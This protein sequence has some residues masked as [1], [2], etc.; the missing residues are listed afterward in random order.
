MDRGFAGRGW[1]KVGDVGE[2]LDEGPLLRNP[3]DG[4]AED[5]DEAVPLLSPDVEG[6]SSDEKEMP[7]STFRPPLLSALST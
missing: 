5:T 1:E 3:A 7:E 6:R 2:D 4:G